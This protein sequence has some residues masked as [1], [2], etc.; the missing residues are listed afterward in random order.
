MFSRL[1]TNR[2]GVLLLLGLMDLSFVASQA[3]PQVVLS[4]ATI[5]QEVT[6]SIG[7]N[8]VTF[9]VVRTGQVTV[10]ASHTDTSSPLPASVPTVLVTGGDTGSVP[11][12]ALLL[13]PF[14]LPTLQAVIT[15]APCV[16]AC[17]QEGLIASAI[18]ACGLTPA[19]IID[20]AC[21]CLSAP[22]AAIHAL[23]NCASAACIGP[24]AGSAGLA[25]DLVAVTSLYNDYCTSAVGANVLSS[26][27][28]SALSTAQVTFTQAP[29]ADPS[30][31]P[32]PAAD[33]S[34]VVTPADP[35]VTVT[36]PAVVTTTGSVDPS[37]P[38]TPTWSGGN[39]TITSNVTLTGNATF[40]GIATLTDS[41]TFV[42]PGITK[43]IM[44]TTPSVAAA[45]T[46][47][48]GTKSEGSV[49]LP[50]K[51]QQAILSLV[52]ALTLFFMI[53]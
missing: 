2:A 53:L 52:F 12:S 19:T 26:V 46:P 50:R 43:G 48:A 1:S 17:L 18:G 8:E 6:L 41:S 13:Q 31:V 28:S 35:A 42:D 22:F 27:L 24:A 11:S 51:S 33:P 47:S 37:S 23:T 25:G 5:T 36:A 7:T 49:E 15:Q 44:T 3:V 20:N 9:G 38:V 10:D 29:A 4:P 34:V 45:S 39:D 40:P 30:V 32:T 21:A 16:S 14:S